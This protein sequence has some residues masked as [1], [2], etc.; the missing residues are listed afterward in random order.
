V[1]LDNKSDPVEAANQ[2]EKL[3][4]EQHVLAILGPVTSGNS[5]AAAPIA[6]DGGVVLFTPT[7]TNPAVTPIGTFIFRACFLDSFQGQTL[8]RFAHK[9]LKASRMA[10]LVENGNDYAKGLGEFTAGEFSKLGGQVV[11]QEYYSKDEKDFTPILTK[12]K[13]A[14]PD[15]IIVPAYYETVG[16]CIK[17]A[18]EM[19][20]TVPILGGDGWDS[21]KLVEIAGAKNLNNT[22]FTNHYSSQ[23]PA[24]EVQ[25]FVHK[26]QAQYHKIPDTFAALGYD[27]A[28]ILFDAIRRAN[29][30]D[31]EKIR[32]ALAQTKDFHG[33]TGAITMGADRNPIK[34]ISVLALKD[35]QQRLVVKMAPQ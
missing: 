13:S 24:T 8:A 1:V 27:T 7:A 4:T 33:V 34:S 20:Y 28:G 5:K 3:I 14:Q 10:V 21:P 2:A 9:Q 6:Q 25:T 32:A 23:D 15:V 29:A 35:G 17:Q 22:Y 30:M 31:S 16:L 18:R 19:G 11:S 12:I 26:Y